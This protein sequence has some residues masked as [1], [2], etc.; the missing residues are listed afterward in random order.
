MN[1]VR[2]GCHQDVT[3]EAVVGS[4]R[5]VFQPEKHRDDGVVQPQ[6][7]E[8][9]RDQQY[10]QRSQC[11]VENEIDLAE[12]VGREGVQLLLRMMH[13][14]KTPEKIEAMLGNMRQIPEEVARQY[15]GKQEQGTGYG[16]VRNQRVVA[17]QTALAPEYDRVKESDPTQLARATRQEPY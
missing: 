8:R 7:Q 5:G 17:Q 6:L 11:R 2:L 14:V 4:D 9:R 16:S 3:Q 13:S 15:S 1:L 10:R 12:P